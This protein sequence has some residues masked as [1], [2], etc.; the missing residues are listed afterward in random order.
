MPSTKK[1]AEISG[2]EKPA[3]C[4]RYEIDGKEIEIA[5]INYNK[6]RITRVGEETEL[7]IFDSSKEAVDYYVMRMQELEPEEE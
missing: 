6:V 2:K 1:N 5:Y 4:R 3:M 7:Y